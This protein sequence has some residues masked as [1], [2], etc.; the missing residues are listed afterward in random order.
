[1]DGLRTEVNT[2]DPSGQELLREISPSMFDRGYWWLLPIV[3]VV[4]F[5]G[6]LVVASRARRR[7]KSGAGH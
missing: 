3:V 6:L 1:M 7:K 5:V 4:L 2:L